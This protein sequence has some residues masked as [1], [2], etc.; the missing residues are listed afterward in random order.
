MNEQGLA[1]LGDSRRISG[2]LV[3]IA[4]AAGFGQF[5]AVASLDDVA[6][7]FGSASLAHTVSGVV[8]LSGSTLGIGLA[9]LRISS[10]LALPLAARAD[11]HGRRRVLMW[12]VVVGLFITS[13]ASA[14][15]NYWFFV[16][17][18]ACARPLLT[19]STT[20]VQVLMAE[21]SSARRRVYRLSLVAAGTGV[22]AGM[23][24]VLHGLVRGPNSFRWLFALA[25]IPALLVIPAVR[26]LPDTYSPASV[27]RV[28]FIERDAIRPLLIVGAISFSMGMISGPANGFAFVYGEGLLK[29]SPHLVAAVV[30]LSAV[31]GV[32]GLLI[33]RR[34]A[35]RFGRRSTVACGVTATALT[36]VVA[37][38]GG[39]QAFILGYLVGVFAA[40][41]FAPA[42]SALVNESFRHHQRATASGWVIVAGVAGAVAGLALF[43][44]VT[45][46]VHV[47][48]ASASL[49]YAALSTFL[50]ALPLISLLVFLPETMGRSLD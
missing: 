4:V 34:L 32:G 15:P 18:F 45:D 49:R 5:G 21:L 26:R 40:G 25:G 16:A 1:H 39:R 35:D 36:S 22:G 37:Y 30:T 41:L 12:A 10:L 7:H 33:S 27:H 6:H 19:V 24:A 17:C 44:Y 20:L 29:I 31:T 38:S 46:A 23:S 2:T 14:A 3:A 43:G 42:A 11:Q 9:I 50:P 28:G 48:E 47:S 8:G 13:L